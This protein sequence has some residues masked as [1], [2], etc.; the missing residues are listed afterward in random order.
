MAD[1]SM[2]PERQ[3]IETLRRQVGE[4]ESLLREEREKRQAA[5]NLRRTADVDSDVCAG[6]T[7]AELPTS[8]QRILA[9][10][11]QREQMELALGESEALYHSLVE[12]LPISV[13]RIDMAGRL[14]FGNSAYLNDIGRPLEELIGKTVFDLFPKEQAAKYDADDRRVMETGEVFCDVEEH[15]VGGGTHYVEVLKSLV[16]NRDGRPIGVQGLYWDVTAQKRAEEQLKTAIAELDRSNQALV[17]SEGLYHSLVEHVPVS[18]YRIDLEGRLTFGNSAYQKDLGRPLEGLLGKTVFD[19]FPKTEA[20][21]YDADD[22]KVI[23]TH[24]PI[25]AVEDHY[26]R[27]NRLYVEVLKCPVFDHEGH[28]V[29]VQGLYW[30]VTAR[31]QAEEQS[32]KTMKELERSNMDLRQFAGV[33]SHDMHAPL[34]WIVK[35]S[36]M[37]QEKY[38]NQLD[39]SGRESLGV[40]LTSAEHMQE[41][42][43][44]LL[45]HSR[46]GTSHKP[47]EAIDCASAVSKAN[48][49]LAFSIE[50]SDAQIQV[51]RLPTVMA[52]KVELVQLFQNLIGNAIKYRGEAAPRIDV[53]AESQGEHWLFRVKDNGIGVPERYREKIFEA[54]K[55]LHSE[56][57]YPGTGIGLAT[58]K[59]IV[60]GLDG[61]IWVES[62]ESEGSVFLFTVPQRGLPEL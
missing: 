61:K 5:E 42:I 13:Y 26:V 27:G 51:A 56:D 28:L 58:C 17:E 45:A 48:S 62:G 30:D 34:R 31:K 55:R 57:N 59:K 36:T 60:E 14:T 33:A 19:L 49:N 25:H 24:A 43:N 40:I 50:E 29:G 16:R 21:K 35:L 10:I 38:A 11:K 2:R 41:L 8:E 52:N 20:S 12:H 44:D 1:H 6:D 3:E 23:E 46:V 47:L 54:F 39:A 37:L 22:Q 53:S 7:A 32:R 18:V 15:R 4:L 9:E